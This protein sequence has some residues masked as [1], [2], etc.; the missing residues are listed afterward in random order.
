MAEESCKTLLQRLWLHIWKSVT[1]IRRRD[2]SAASPLNDLMRRFQ[3]SIYIPSLNRLIAAVSISS[4][5]MCGLSLTDPFLLRSSLLRICVND[6][7]L[8]PLDFL[9]SLE[10]C[11]PGII[12]AN[13]T[14]GP[15][16]VVGQRI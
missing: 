14:I 11:R 3:L 13:K 9:Q 2:N 12:A 6:I 10:Y 8:C 1:V 5:R 4:R 15:L 16:R 7:V